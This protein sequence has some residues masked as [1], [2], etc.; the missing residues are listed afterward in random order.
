VLAEYCALESSNR[1]VEERRMPIEMLLVEDNESDVR[2][3]REV[4]SEINEN[5]RLHVVPDGLEAISFLTYQGPYLSAPRPHVILLDLRMPKMDGLEVLGRI[6]SDPWLRTIPVIVLTTSR[7]E[8]DIAQSYK[9]L[10][11]CYL[12]KP[13]ELKEFEKLVSSLNEFWLTKVALPKEHATP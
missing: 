3:L 10:A 13:G 6:K 8:T 9:L 1:V 11:N 4:L 7:A 2:L 5:V 12:I